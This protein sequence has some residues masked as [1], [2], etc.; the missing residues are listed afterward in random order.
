VAYFNVL[1]TSGGYTGSPGYTKLHFLPASNAG[2]TTSEVN[3]AAAASRVLL[4]A[5]ASNMPTGV[6]YSCVSPA[7]WFDDSGV[8][9]GEVSI[10]SLPS[11]IAG[12]GAATYPGGCGAVIYWNTGAING[13]HKVR[14]RTYLVPLSSGAFANDGT[15]STALVTSLQ[16]AVNT[17]VGTVPPPCV[18]SRSLGKPLR[19][20]S[21][22]AV[23]TG[24]VKDRSAFLRTRRT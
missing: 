14:G 8:L 3:A 18:N 2:P 15:L 11:P 10:T 20:N 12:S 19:G 9:K 7:Q 1:W 24:S 6:T 17:F 4:A 22:Y 16:T 13:G 21:T 23:T 5:T